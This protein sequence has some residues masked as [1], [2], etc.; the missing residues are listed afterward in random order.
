[1][2]LFATS[3]PKSAHLSY[4]HWN[5]MAVEIACYTKKTRQLEN[6]RHN[7]SKRLPKM[8]VTIAL[9]DAQKMTVTT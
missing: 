1:M 4:Y 8:T 9:D 2:K 7:S 6:G 3:L 5:A